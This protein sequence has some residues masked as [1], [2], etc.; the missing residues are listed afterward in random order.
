MKPPP[1]HKPAAFSISKPQERSVKRLFKNLAVSVMIAASLSVRLAA[2]D[3]LSGDFS[4]RTEIEKRLAAVRAETSALPPDTDPSLRERFQQLEA[5]CQFHLAA[6]DVVAKAQAGRDDAAQTLTAWRGFPQPPPY[7][8]L[9][10]DDV[11]ET[12][13]TLAAAQRASEAQLRIFTAEIEAARD[14]LDSHQQA[15]RKFMDAVSSAGTP[16]ARQS[17]ERSVKIEQV[18][19][20]I[21]AEVVARANLRL[22]AQQAELDM[23]RPQTELAKLQE[24]ALQGNTTFSQKDLDEIL[25]GISRSKEEALAALVAASRQAQSPNPLLAWKTEFLDLEK[26]FW[27]TRFASFGKKDPAIVKKAL[28]TLGEQKSRV[29]DWMEI[30]QLRLSGGATGAAEID[31]E[32]LRESLQQVSRMQRR[33]A[34]ATADLGGG[35]LEMPA[36]DLIGS[37]LGALW[38]TELYLAEETE[39]VNGSKISTLRAVTVGKLARL[40]LI[41]T[42]GWLLLR[43][44]SRKVQSIV[45]KKTGISQSAAELIAKLAFGLGLALLVVYGLNTVRIP[46]TVFAF[47]GG[48]LAIGVGFGTQ[49]MLKNFISGIILIFE[50]P[51]RIGDT[52][53]IEG[54]TGTIRSI[55]MRASTIKHSD[56]IDTIIP[57]S[58]LLESNVTNWT[59]SDTLLRHSVTVA[60]DYFSPTREVS[61]ALLAVADEHGLVLKEPKPEVRFEDFGDKALVFRLLFWFDTKKTTCDTLASDLRFMIEKSFTEAGLNITSPQRDIQINPQSSLRIELT[62]T[63]SRPT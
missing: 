4:K 57:N 13:A 56:G 59:L 61:Q 37:R 27:N 58:T 60:V 45:S 18:S 7:S 16:A 36:M 15:E 63:T 55:G 50:R 22:Q 41:L 10:L 34:F 32:K 2:Q 28:A 42:V 54:V 46:F 29:D 38:D 12:L 40:A 9:L 30:A 3:A 6:L 1:K 51:L 62:K 24:K 47:L 26:E 21:A 39:V 19:S 33:I 25:Q 17:A 52:V 53:Q 11:R 31:P 8:I 48:A 44:I 5:I 20:R 35:H 49:T 43:F 14:K 23:I